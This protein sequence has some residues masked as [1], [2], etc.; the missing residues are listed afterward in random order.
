MLGSCVEFIASLICRK[1]KLLNILKDSELSHAC[2]GSCSWPMGSAAA[3]AADAVAATWL[4]RMDV[5][6]FMLN[7]AV[8]F[9][10]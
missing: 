5:S 10:A 2:K 8:K 4:C 1:R 6:C 9:T 7:R 3:A